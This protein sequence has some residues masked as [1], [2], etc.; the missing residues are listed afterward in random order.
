MTPNLKPVLYAED[1][2]NDVFFMQRA[3][4]KLQIPNVL[5]TVPDGRL[6]IA[7]LAG[8]KPY[9]NREEHPLPCLLMLDLSM[10][11]KRGLEVLKWMK[12]EPSLSSLPVVVMT[13]SNQESDIHQSYLLGANG[14]LIKPG[15]P[16]SLLRIV[17]TVADY[18]LGEKRPEG[19]FVDFA[20]A[21]V[22]SNGRVP[23]R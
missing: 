18:W 4:Q 19:S 20:S 16:E 1:D 11:G 22:S 15:D 12:G 17:K 10:P 8:T 9:E 3:F 21:A 13:S 7:Y 5:L 14:F 2:E 6:A 23:P